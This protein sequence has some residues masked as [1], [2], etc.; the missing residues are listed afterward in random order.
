M[1]LKQVLY[2]HKLNPKP[3]TT[4]FFLLFVMGFMGPLNTLF[5]TISFVAEQEFIKIC[6]FCCCAGIFGLFRHILY[7]HLYA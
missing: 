6:F 2:H 7:H 3:F 1:K 4:I 5:T